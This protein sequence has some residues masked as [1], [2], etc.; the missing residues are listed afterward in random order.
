MTP[1]KNKDSSDIE[2]AQNKETKVDELKPEA[3]AEE[4]EEPED[5]DDFEDEEPEDNDD[6]DDEDDDY[7]FYGFEDDKANKGTYAIIIR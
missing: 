4:D 1:P 6:F 2:Q 3:V 7:E 5:N